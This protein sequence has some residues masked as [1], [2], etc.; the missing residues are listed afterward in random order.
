MLIQGAVG[1]V[2]EVTRGL[3]LGCGLAVDL[4]HAFLVRTLG[5]AGQPVEVRA[6]YPLK[7][8]VWYRRLLAGQVTWPLDEHR[9]RAI[10]EWWLIV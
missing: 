7:V 2:V 9:G 6:S 1:D 8:R 3:P 5:S 4:L 10:S